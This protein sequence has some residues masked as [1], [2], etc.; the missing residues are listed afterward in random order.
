MLGKY[1]QREQIVNKSQDRTILMIIATVLRYSLQYPYKIIHWGKGYNVFEESLDNPY[2]TTSAEAPSRCI[3]MNRIDSV[4]GAT[5]AEF[6]T[7]LPW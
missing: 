4:G 5:T 6:V 2:G 7:I 1:V 3:R